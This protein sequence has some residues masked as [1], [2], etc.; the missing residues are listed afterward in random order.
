V[1]A[2]PARPAR[3]RRGGF[4]DIHDKLWAPMASLL[5]RYDDHLRLV[6]G[7]RYEHYDQED[8]Q[9]DELGVTRGTSSVER[10]IRCSARTTTSSCATAS[11]ITRRTCSV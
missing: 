6:A 3:R 11:R 4:P 1:T 9:F 2:R 5:Y 10:T 7:Y 8:W